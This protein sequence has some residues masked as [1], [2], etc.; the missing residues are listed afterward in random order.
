MKTIFKYI[1]SPGLN[2]FEM[3][4]GSVVL[5]AREQGSNVCIWAEV[6]TNVLKK[7]MRRFMVFGTGH[8]MHGDLDREF[9]G[10]AL[11]A[12]DDLVLHVFEVL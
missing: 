8:E 10:T 12:A 4:L 3:P 9:L 7:E 1:L 11:I 5:S 6:N 2:S